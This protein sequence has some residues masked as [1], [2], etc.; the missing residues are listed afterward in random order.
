MKRKGKINLEIA[1]D[2]I[3]L[4]GSNIPE[5]NKQQF[6]GRIERALGGQAVIFLGVIFALVGVLYTARV[7]QLQIVNGDSFR[8]RS[9]DNSLR[10]V[11]LRTERA[12]IYDR[13]NELLAWNKPQIGREYKDL[14]GLAH[15]LGYLGFPSREEIAQEETLKPDI[16][17]GKQGVE[18]VYEERLR[19][20]IGEKFQEVDSLGRVISENLYRVPKDGVPLSLTIDSRLQSSLY[21]KMK[22]VADARDFSGGAGIIMDV[23]NGDVLALISF[24]EFSP[25]ELSG[26]STPAR[27]NT[28]FSDPRTPF[29]NRAVSGQYAPGSIVKPF[30]A[31]AAL[32]EKIISPD[33]EIL[34]AGSIEIPNP[35]IRGAVSI[36]KD[37]KAHGLVD[38]R[39]AIAVS[40]NVY[41]YEIG[42]GYKSLRGLG[43]SRIGEYSKMF[44][45]GQTSGIDLPGELSGTVPTPK[46]KRDLFNGEDWLLGDTYHT[47]I[48]QYGFL[49]TPIQMVRATAAIAN[50]GRLLTPHVAASSTAEGR[51]IPI[52]ESYFQIVREGMRLSTQIGTGV[53]LNVP[54]ITFATKTGT[55]ELGEA[56]AKVN[57]WIEGFFPYENPRYAFAIVMERGHVGNTIGAAY[58]ARQFFDW[59]NIYT[60]EYY[61]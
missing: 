31:I 38:M 35:F 7:G 25:S 46:W 48:G 44:G 37:W 14:P 4:D 27:V 17:I 54:Y 10:Q 58:V 53:I 30:M 21:N 5:F 34:S 12:A 52:P 36:F 20:V 9:E 55:A 1:P 56:K 43:I 2:E 57:S 26:S 16:R 18:K 19:G 28:L 47:S 23:T 45:F 15:V 39:H 24:P 49:V 51:Q 13:N 41:F 11:V 42:G 3:L 61:Y 8:I 22:E 50:G 32:N 29:L 59:M 6:E 60:P 40:S 33:T